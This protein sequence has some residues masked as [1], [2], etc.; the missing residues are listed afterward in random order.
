MATLRKSPRAGKKYMVALNDRKDTRVHFGATGY[1][2]FTLHKDAT[3]KES[4]ISRHRPG[5]RWGKSGIK[6]AGFWA[7]WVLWN[8]PT[9]RGSLRDI[10]R[11]FGI[12]VRL[13]IG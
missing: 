6:T 11:R 10:K 13:E 3:R 5:Q 8:K 7:R 2:D 1:S 4:Y 12:S 9:L